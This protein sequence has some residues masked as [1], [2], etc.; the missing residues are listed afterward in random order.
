MCCSASGFP[1]DCADIRA[2][3][4]PGRR[5][6][7]AP[8]E[9]A[10]ARVVAGDIDKR[11]AVS[12]RR[13]VVVQ[14]NAGH[15][16]AADRR[17]PARPLLLRPQGG[18]LGVGAAQLRF[19]LLAHGLFYL[20]KAASAVA[21]NTFIN[22]AN[23]P[24]TVILVSLVE[25]VMAIMLLAHVLESRHGAPSPRGT[26]RADR[27]R[28]P[29]TALDNRRALYLRAPHAAG[30]GLASHS[31]CA[32]LLIDIDHFKRVSDLHG[33]D[34]GDRLLLTL[35]DLIRS[36]LRAARTGRTAGRGRVRDRAA[37][38]RPRGSAGA[39]PGLARGLRTSR[40]ATMFET[41]RNRCR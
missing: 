36:A 25:G 9:E 5:C 1:N 22:L 3:A 34:A 39:G 17:Q 31:P 29:L 28:D 13:A 11:N 12:A 20:A 40:R 2:L 19:V 16:V 35:S 26:H 18:T 14:G 38:R 33:P 30:A 41:R 7:V 23:F 6:R 24:G 21:L 27:R 32:L 8:P 10:A 4:V 15:P 37:Q